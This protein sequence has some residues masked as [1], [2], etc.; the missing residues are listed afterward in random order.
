M[1]LFIYLSCSETLR[2]F[3]MGLKLGNNPGML[4]D[5]FSAEGRLH[6]GIVPNGSCR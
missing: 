2:D 5:S 3:F 6:D 4:A 1:L